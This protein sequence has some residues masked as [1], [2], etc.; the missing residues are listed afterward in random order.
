MRSYLDYL[1]NSVIN[2]FSIIP[3][4]FYFRPQL[5]PLY[6]FYP[7]KPYSNVIPIVYVQLLI[8]VSVAGRSMHFFRIRVFCVRDKMSIG[9]RA[10]L[11]AY[12]SVR[13]RTANTRIS[14]PL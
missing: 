10:V 8:Y 7:R 1:S 6:L 14:L 2:L 12:R 4:I 3:L 5:F 9:V 13:L 11:P